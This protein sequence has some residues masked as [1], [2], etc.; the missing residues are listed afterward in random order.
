[1]ALL[2]CFLLVGQDLKVGGPL[3]NPIVFATQVPIPGDFVTI[4]STFGNH[5]ADMASVGR[6]GDLYIVYPTG[7]IKNLT[8]VA[9]YGMSGHQ[10]ST[11]IAVRDPHVHW[12]GTKV[13]FSMAI[14]AP[15]QF[16]Y[17][18]YF[19]QLY[20]VTG[21]GEFETPVITLVPNQPSNANNIQP[22]YGSDD[23]IIFASDRPFRGMAHLYPLLD[24]YEEAATVNGLWSLD[25]VSGDLS[26]INHTPSGAFTPFLDSSGRIIFTRWDHLQRDQQA[27]ADELSTTGTIYGTFNYSDETAG[28][29]LNDSREEFFPEPRAVRTDLLAGTNLEG[30]SF[31]LFFPWQIMEDGTAE[32]TLNHIGRHELSNYFNRSMND[33]PN[34][35]EFI[36]SVSGRFN[37]NE[38]LNFFHLREDPTQAGRFIGVDAPEFQSHASGQL[39]AINGGET[40]NPDLMAITYV[41]HPDT[42]DVTNT[43]D[44]T[45]TGLYRDPIYLSDGSILAVHTPETR[46]DENEGS[47]ALPSSRYDFRIKRIVQNGAYF[48]A[49]TPIT[50]GITKSITYYDPDVLVTYNGEFWE[51]YPVELVARTRPSRT[52]AALE[53][54]ETQI[55]NE[56]NVDIQQFKQWMADEGL[57]LAVSRNVT[58]RDHADQQQPYNLRVPGGAQTISSG[59]TVYDISHLQFFQADHL[60]GIGGLATP[61]PGRRVLAQP[62]HDP[63]VNNPPGGG[64]PG[65]VALDQDGSMAAFVPAHRAMSWQLTAPDTT[66]VVRERYWVNFQPGEIRVCASCHGINTTHQSGGGVPQNP[67]EAL[68]TLLQYW[69]TINCAASG[70]DV[71]QSGRVEVLDAVPVINNLASAGPYDLNCD[72][73]VDAQDLG[74]ILEAWPQTP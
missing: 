54:P 55:F 40:T 72:G 67:P 28:A 33:D 11:A 56:E 34:L 38:I 73:T 45:H 20:E 47:R 53:A 41:T 51:L 27:D 6:G 7:T 66:P 57:A 70:P 13:I 30:H 71:N 50:T 32:E 1:M 25:P 60:R 59:G 42:A 4:G 14:G 46:A 62:M 16:I 26:R 48:E 5:Q 2:L 19:W 17:E 9:G 22:I 39:I 58:T 10:G 31:N 12:D 3:P 36:A 64:P 15:T 61:S 44:P 63:A 69:K 74:L 65:S 24:E 29:S 49:G 68:R 8:Q 43:P 52:P 21:L 23:R 37:T 18:D 35:D